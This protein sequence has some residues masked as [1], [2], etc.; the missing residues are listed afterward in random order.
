M[1]TKILSL[2]FIFCFTWQ[3][4]AQTENNRTIVN[5]NSTW[6]VLGTIVASNGRVWTQYVY[7]EGDSIVGVNSFKKVFSCDDSLH[8]NI[9]YE[10]LIREEDKKTYFIP[11]NSDSAY[12]LYDFSLTEGTVF[13]YQNYQTQEID[14]LYVKHIDSIA[15]NGALKTRIQ[16]TSPPPYD[17]RIVETWIEHIGSLS[18]IIY[19]KHN[20]FLDGVSYIL[21]C[22]YQDGEL[23]YKNPDYSECYYEGNVAV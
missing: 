4:K 7:F 11:V 22:Y 1:K 17:N 12:L 14:S 13:E 8:E 16:L 2:A 21:L 5:D 6:S 18:G 20:L 23:V 10:G 19:V 3:A 9:T 15:I